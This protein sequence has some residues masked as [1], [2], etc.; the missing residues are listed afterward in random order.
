MRNIPDK[1]VEKIKKHILYSKFVSSKCD[2]NV[3]LWK[4]VVKPDRPQ[5]AI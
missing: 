4:Y 5:M 2:V 1:T 3:I